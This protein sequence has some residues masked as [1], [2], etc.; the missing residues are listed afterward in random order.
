M[1]AQGI[2]AQ[3][4]AYFQASFILLVT[5]GARLHIFKHHMSVVNSV[6]KLRCDIRSSE[7]TS[8]SG[9]STLPN[10]SSTR[11]AELICGSSQA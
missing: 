8:L 9:E 2:F 11:M 4:T 3:I 1:P 5:Y 6:Y 10:I 7:N